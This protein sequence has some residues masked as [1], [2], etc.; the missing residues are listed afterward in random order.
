M[1]FDFRKAK[2]THLA[3]C[4]FFTLFSSLGIFRVSGSQYPN[5]EIRLL[6]LKCRSGIPTFVPRPLKKTIWD[7]PFA[8]L[9]EVPISHFETDAV[10]Y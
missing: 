1:L 2:N 8:C 6:F 5:T 9:Q 3:T 10:A 7:V 4:V